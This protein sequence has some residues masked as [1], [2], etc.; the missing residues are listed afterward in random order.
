MKLGYARVSTANQSL[1]L[2]LDA[3]KAAG[4][5]PTHIYIDTISGGK[6]LSS[7]DRINVRAI[8]WWSGARQGHDGM[9]RGGCQLLS[10]RPICVLPA[11]VSEAWTGEFHRERA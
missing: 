4:C 6:D 7:S 1:D 3:L 8:P 9:R 2:Q 5:T 10:L 11:H